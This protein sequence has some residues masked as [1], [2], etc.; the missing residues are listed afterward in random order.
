MA[1]VIHKAVTPPPQRQRQLHTNTPHST[2][3]T[4]FQVGGREF[5]AERANAQ[6]VHL[7]G[8]CDDALLQLTVALGWL[9]DLLAFRPLM[10]ERSQLLLGAYTTTRMD[11]DTCTDAGTPQ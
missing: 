2:L 10:C 4:P 5:D 9:D 11:T 3:Y 8:D 6:N 7:P 1:C